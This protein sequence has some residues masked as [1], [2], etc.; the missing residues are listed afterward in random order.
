M[1]RARAPLQQT[2][3]VVLVC[4][5]PALDCEKKVTGAESQIWAE[6]ET[7]FLGIVTY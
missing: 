3:A 4:P 5:P 6:A 1:F 7:L 2:E